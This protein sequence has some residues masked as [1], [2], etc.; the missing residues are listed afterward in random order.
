MSIEHLNGKSACK[1]VWVARG[2]A[3]AAVRAHFYINDAE[4]L[5]TKC[6]AHRDPA[7]AEVLGELNFRTKL[8]AR[9]KF[10]AKQGCPDLVYDSG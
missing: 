9:P 2:N 1:P 6:I 4:R 5:R 3:G 10:F 7:Y 8:V